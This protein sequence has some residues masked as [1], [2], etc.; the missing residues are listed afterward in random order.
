MN[1]AGG[2]ASA[3]VTG[4]TGSSAGLEWDLGLL[5][6]RPSQLVVEVA[7]S[8]RHRSSRGR[9][10]PAV[11]KP[12]ASANGMSDRI[13]P[14]AS[15]AQVGRRPAVRNGGPDPGQPAC[16]VSGDDDPD[17]ERYPPDGIRGKPS[18]IPH[19]HELQL[20]PRQPGLV[21]A[22]HSAV[23]DAW[24]PLKPASMRCCPFSFIFGI[25]GL[26]ILLTSHCPAR[27]QRQSAF[28]R[29]EGPGNTGTK[30]LRHEGQRPC[31]L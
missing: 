5:S 10:H 29:L 8:V 24:D 12:P 30:V 14:Q 21:I 27:A 31:C 16:R 19:P 7:A 13:C 17:V 26:R 15:A 2:M 25:P 9:I 3:P 18:R 20:R 1:R 6:E 23:K 11:D 22:H 4:R 28:L